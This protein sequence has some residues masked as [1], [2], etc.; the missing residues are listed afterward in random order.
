VTAITLTRQLV[1]GEVR[2]IERPTL[3]RPLDLIELAESIR[4]RRAADPKL[5]VRAIARELDRSSPWVSNVL[6]LLKLPV[7]GQELVRAGRLSFAHARAIANLSHADQ[8]TLIAE[9]L[10]HRISAHEIERASRRVR[11]IAVASN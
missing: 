9:V 11:T 5:T 6:R 7:A 2:L 1:R 4:D 8:L 3:G 10:S